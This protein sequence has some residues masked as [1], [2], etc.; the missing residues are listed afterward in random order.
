M[1]IT[2]EQRRYARLA[3]ILFILNYVLQIFGDSVTII[4]RNGESF[5]ETA[6]FAA[7]SAVLW[8]VCLLNVGVAW[9]VIGVLAVALYAVLE[10][11]NRRLAQLALGL[12]LDASFVGASSLMFRVAEARLYQASTKEGLFTVEQ[13]R[14]L[15][16]ASVRASSAGVEIAWLCQAA[17]S[18]LFFVLFLRSGYLPRALA[19]TGILGAALIVPMSIG[20][21]VYPVAVTPLKLVG[22]PNLFAEIVTASLLIRGLR[23]RSTASGP[24]HAY[25]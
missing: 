17:G 21:F 6:R 5:A 1:S 13:L 4:L 7:Q 19:W 3:G 25:R 15:V 16:A 22:L 8:R 24:E 18:L 9:I 11:V 23:S 14:T 12:R 2:Q 10:P 20:M